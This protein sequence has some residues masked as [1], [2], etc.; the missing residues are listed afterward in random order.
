MRCSLCNQHCVIAEGKTGLCGV[1][2]NKGGKLYT[3]VY[4]KAISYNVDP[5][6]KKP[7]Y[8]FLPG[9]YSFSFA[10]VGC[11][12]SCLH[13]QNWEISQYSREEKREVPGM[14][15]S[16]EEIVELARDYDCRSVSYT[17]TEPTIF[18][19]YAYDTAR[20]AAGE[21]LKNIFV[22]NGYTGEG[23]LEEISPYLHAANVDLKAYSEDFY[24]KVCGARLEPVLDNIELYRDLGIWI[25]VTTLIIPGYNDS[26][27]DLKGIAS[28]LSD[29]DQEIPWHVTRFHPEYNLLSVP[30]TPLETLTRAR[31][32]GLGEG[33]S[34]VYIGNVPGEEGQNT[35]C[36]HCGA[37]LIERKGFKPRVR[38]MEGPRCSQCGQNIGGVFE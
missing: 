31:D 15:L 8:H 13:C 4:G 24:R 1:R 10:T 34:Y 18:Y 35:F 36:P 6:E 5:I 27:E 12:F 7:L 2:L 21:G 28:F 30:S 32:I 33:L 16:P 38:M 26:E 3:V 37:E 14:D 25:E 19:E 9:T 29:L 17:Y 11:N 22:T 23:A 20:I